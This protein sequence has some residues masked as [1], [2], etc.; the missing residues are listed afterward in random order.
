MEVFMKIF[1]ALCL[2]IFLTGAAYAQEASPT[3]VTPAS[4]IKDTPKK[5]AAAAFGLSIG[6]SALG[7]GA[8][9]LSISNA[10]DLNVGRAAIYGVLGLSLTSVGPSFGH[11]YS[12]AGL[13]AA[14]LTS[15]R[16]L[17]F[18]VPFI[19]DQRAIA[20]GDLNAGTA[21]GI[22]SFALGVLM[23]YD[24][25]DAPLSVR[26]VERRAEKAALQ[27]MPTLLPEIGGGRVS[28]LMAGFQF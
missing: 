24:W 23:I 15:A 26:R 5:S 14:I 11:I 10:A 20:Q 21:T 12:G 2:S 13:H 22:G 8:I 9:A 1:S 16:L 28:G 27:V 19:I 7:F 18:G 3:A 4:P 6:G 25:I 17:S